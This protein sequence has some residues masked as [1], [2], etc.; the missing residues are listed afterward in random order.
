MCYQISYS[1]CRA[2]HGSAQVYY[3]SFILVGDKFCQPTSKKRIVIIHVIIYVINIKQL[4]AYIVLSV[5]NWR[6]DS[7][8]TINLGEIR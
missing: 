4:Y 3:T 1:V 5:S 7:L 8:Q 2:A 6:F